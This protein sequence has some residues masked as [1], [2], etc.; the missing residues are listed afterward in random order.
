MPNVTEELKVALADRYVIESE[1]GEG[2]MATVYL[3]HDVKHDRKVALKVLRPELAAVIGADRFLAEIKTTANLQHPHILPLHDSGEADG[4]LYYV[5]PYVQGESLRD[6][7]DRDKQLPVDQ[8]VNIVREVADALDYAHRH[9]V[10]H[11]DIKPENILLHDDRAMV[12]DFGIALAV[13]SAGSSRMTETG[14]SLGTPNYM[15][16]EQAMGERELSPTSDVYSLGAVLYELLV[17]EPPFGGP[18]A[19]AIVA[20]VVTESP[21]PLTPQRHTVP[22][23]VEAAT[24]KALEKLPADR[25]ASAAEFSAAL[26][27]SGF[28][29]QIRE[30]DATPETETPVQRSRTTM[31][32]SAV[33]VIAVVAAAAG[34]L[35]GGPSASPV[36]RLDL[37]L[38]DIT[39]RSSF[40][41][42][43]TIS[44]DGSMLAFAGER[45][46][47]D[48]IF[49]RRLGEADFH[50]VPGTEGG[51][52]PSFSPINPLW[53]H[54]GE[55]GTVAF[56]SS[57]GLFIVPAAGGPIRKLSPGWAAVP[58]VLPDGS[59]VLYS[60]FPQDGVHL[61]DLKMDSARTI[62][63]DGRHAVYVATG[64]IL[65]QPTS[66]GLF[67]VPFDLGRG[68]VTGPPI[69][70]LD[71]VAARGGRPGYAVSRGGTLLHHEG[72]VAGGTGLSHLA[73]LHLDGR[74]DTLPLPPGLRRH[75][76]FSPDGRTIA[77]EQRR[78]AGNSSRPTTARPP[79]WCW[80]TLGISPPR[81]GCPMAGWC[82]GPMRPVTETCLSTRLRMAGTPNPTSRPLGTRGGRPFRR[83]RRWRR[84]CPVRQGSGRCGCAISPCHRASGGCR[85]AGASSPGGHPMARRSIS[86][87]SHRGSTACSRSRS[88]GSPPWWCARRSCSSRRRCRGGTRGTC[89]PTGTGF[90]WCCRDRPAPG[91]KRATSA[92]WW[93]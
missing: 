47:N 79:N 43:V 45:N 25:F 72:D 11:R 2:G 62:I 44:P 71:R 3:A 91:V 16:P 38:A 85:T 18:T 82:S 51:D 73:L 13:T 77:Y 12:A 60:R 24:I 76:R 5:M 21:R 15:S 90:S 53:P 68:E 88:S 54:W 84:S 32:L 69:R 64:H 92:I 59:G 1:L 28:A 29:S 50:M 19:Q 55:D 74:V 67:A 75:P 65:Y 20:R 78:D 26:A 58:H 70:V 42:D 17:G 49:L 34:W 22:R 46:G 4:F 36:V 7:L 57:G 8:A 86:G 87:G 40:R 33:T 89:I 14:M 81:S 27:D 41:N 35:R 93:C 23:H 31:V 52:T 9:E 39:L 61:Y 63:P 66:G 37:D 80:T 30:V 83:M 56:G 6:L 10:I 48:G